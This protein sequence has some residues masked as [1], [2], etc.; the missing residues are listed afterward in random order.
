MWL[1]KK[2]EP[3]KGTLIELKEFNIVKKSSHHDFSTRIEK[4][5][6]FVWWNVNIEELKNWYW[7]F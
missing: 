4:I 7:I 1:G 3:V 6:S 5:I 2:E